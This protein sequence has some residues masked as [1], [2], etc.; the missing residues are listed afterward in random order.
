M[1]SVERD[2]QG[3]VGML[4]LGLGSLNNFNRFWTVGGVS[5]YMVPSSGMI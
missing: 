2:G 5:S 3:G 4:S 1:V